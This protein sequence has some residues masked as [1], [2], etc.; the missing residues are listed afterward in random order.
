M[1]FSNE[2]KPKTGAGLEDQ[3]RAAAQRIRESF[4][5]RTLAPRDPVYVI[6]PALYDECRRT[7]LIDSDGRVVLSATVDE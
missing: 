6:P 5:S 1:S 3:L 7:G 4:V 2:I